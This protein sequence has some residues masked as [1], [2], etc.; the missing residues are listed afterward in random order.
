MNAEAK[1]RALLRPAVFTEPGALMYAGNCSDLY[2]ASLAGKV[3]LSAWTRR[4]YPGRP[5][6]DALPQV[7]S[8]GGWDAA[9]MQ[10]WGLKEH[11]NEGVKIAYMARGSMILKID[12]QRHEVSEGQMFVVRPWQLHQFGDP[13]V[14]A[15]QIVWVLFDVGVR[16]PHENWLWPDWMAWSERDIDRLTTLLSRNEQHVLTASREVARTF[17]DIAQIVAGNDVVGSETRM[18]LSISTLLLQ[19]ME[20]L[21]SQSPQ[22]DADLASSKRT[23]QIFLDRLSH[24]LDEDWTLENMAAE[25]SLSRTQFSQ[26]CQAITNMTPVRYLQMIRLEAA[27]RWLSERANVSVTEIALEAGFTSSQYFATCY[28]RRFGLTP[29]E[30]RR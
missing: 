3:V 5:L 29:Q 12:G 24:A 1:A 28:K 4:K 22:L 9:R 16:R 18:R 26:H 10:D 21:E 20:Q 27:K 14:G 15:S 7:L 19:F 13:H 23:V 17:H 25:C 30:S 6:G 8:V 2:E 11:C